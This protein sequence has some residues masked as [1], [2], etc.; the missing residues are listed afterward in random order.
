MI[1]AT[2]F[3]VVLV[4]WLIKEDEAWTFVHAAQQ[5]NLA[6]L[7]Q[8]LSSGFDPN[9]KVYPGGVTALR[10]A[11]ENHKQ[12][13]VQLLLSNGADPN[14]GIALAVNMNQPEI[15]DLLLHEGANINSKEISTL[16]YLA[17]QK[18]DKKMISV[19]KSANGSPQV[20]GNK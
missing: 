11:I 1:L 10:M 6:K 2:L 5:G 14:D 7:S 17:E 9:T 13:A 16:L 12:A 15:V 3:L 19:L 8:E 20:K 4:Y 18:G